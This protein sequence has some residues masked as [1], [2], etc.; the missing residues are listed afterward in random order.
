MPGHPGGQSLTSHSLYAGHEGKPLRHLTQ[1][2]PVP[3]TVQVFLDSAYEGTQDTSAG[4]T[5]S[6]A[7]TSLCLA[8]ARR[9]GS[10]DAGSPTSYV[11][12]SPDCEYSD[13]TVRQGTD[14]L[15]P[16]TLWEW[17]GGN[18]GYTCGASSESDLSGQSDSSVVALRVQVCFVFRH[19]GRPFP[20]PSCRHSN[21]PSCLYQSVDSA[22][23]CRVC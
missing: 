10:C 22:E 7:M 17:L 18:D 6:D 9:H 2:S 19:A 23:T 3:N 16:K 14:S 4:S 15:T 1:A 12:R 5:M 13:W 11:G 8:S 20:T 21:S